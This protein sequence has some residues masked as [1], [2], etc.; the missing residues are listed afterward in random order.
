MDFIEHLE[1]FDAVGFYGHVE[2]RGSR[3]VT[4]ID[5]TSILK[6]KF[7]H[8]WGIVADRHEQRLIALLQ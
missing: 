2:C 3:I 4:P 6:Q 5:F 1:T 7:D 8:H